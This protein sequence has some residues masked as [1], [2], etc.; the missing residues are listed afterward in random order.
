MNHMNFRSAFSLSLLI[1]LYCGCGG[2][3]KTPAELIVGKWRADKAAMRETYLAGIKQQGLYDEDNKTLIENRIK[4]WVTMT[5]ADLEFRDD[6]TYSLSVT[7]YDGSIK[8]Q[9]KWSI[10][11]SDAESVL[12]ELRYSLE[13]KPVHVKN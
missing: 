13:G 1:L 2:G 5:V 10:Q 3:E 7:N 4:Q 11:S 9:G 12:V 6:N 8:H